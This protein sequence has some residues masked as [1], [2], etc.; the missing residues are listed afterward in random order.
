MK[1]SPHL[2]QVASLVHHRCGKMFVL[3]QSR[4]V[5]AVN[6]LRCGITLKLQLGVPLKD[7]LTQRLHHYQNLWSCFCLL[8]AV[9]FPRLLGTSTS[10]HVSVL[11]IRS[12][13][14]P[15]VTKN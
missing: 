5:T 8:L 15:T 12:V 13:S 9:C 14:S 3:A 4:R 1:S 6:E 11:Q 2:A 10:I 7:N